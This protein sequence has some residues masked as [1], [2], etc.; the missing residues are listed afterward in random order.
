MKLNSYQKLKKKNEDLLEDI[1]NI[2]IN[3]DSEIGAKTKLRYRFR[4]LVNKE[5]M[6]G[7]PNKMSFKNINNILKI[8]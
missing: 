1:Y 8:E 5:I 4:F 2:V 6:S 7:D 3:G